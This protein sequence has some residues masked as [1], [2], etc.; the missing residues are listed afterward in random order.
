M[1]TAAP[2]QPMRLLIDGECP[3]C[4]REGAFLMRLDRNRGRL[5][6][7]D[8]TEPDFD[9]ADYGATQDD[10]M[11][12][13]HART[14]DGRIVTGME[15]FRHAYRA[16]GLGWLLAPT[17]WPVLRPIFDAFYRWFARNRLR[18]TGRPDE[19]ETGRCKV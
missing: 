5:Q 17:G 18:L 10:V 6:L 12:S 9:A 13:I 1:A 16:V 8:I 14:P 19:C 2:N 11:G 15:A 7:I 4:R 3:L